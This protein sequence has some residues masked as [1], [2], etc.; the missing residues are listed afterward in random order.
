LQASNA[1]P[2]DILA[3][4]FRPGLVLTSLGTV[5]GLAASLVVTHL[6]SSLLFAVSAIDPLT[7]VTIP[8]LLGI[9]TVAACSIPARRATN[10][11]PVETLRY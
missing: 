8:V 4:A 1:Q 11:S 2:C 7:F 10:I 5:I 9:V 6:M 3:L